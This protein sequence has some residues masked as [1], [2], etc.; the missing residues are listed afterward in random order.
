MAFLSFEADGAVMSFTLVLGGARSGKSRHAEELIEAHAAPWT[1]IATAQ[2]FDDEMRARISLHRARR[3][4]GWTTVDAPIALPD[5]IREADHGQAILVD[6]LTL[7]LTNWR[8]PMHPV[9]APCFESN[10][11]ADH[12]SIESVA[13]LLEA[14]SAAPGPLV[15]VGNEIGLGVI[16]MGAEVRAF[17]DA[18]GRLNQQVAEVCAR[19]TLMAAGLPL[20]L[21]APA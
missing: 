1:Y 12:A 7:W 15:L 6:C 3:P 17:V 20:T 19:V 10:P 16:P 5:A 8:M 18:L 9:E 14:I 13:L 11:A 2:A 21:K 4:Q